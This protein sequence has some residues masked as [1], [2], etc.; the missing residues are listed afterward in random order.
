MNHP[1]AKPALG[2]RTPFDDHRLLQLL[3]RPYTNELKR[4]FGPLAEEIRA[5]LRVARRWGAKGP[6]P[7]GKQ[8][9]GLYSLSKQRKGVNP[10]LS[11]QV[12]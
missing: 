9:R 8:G 10:P 4:V 11:G 3:E 1:T 2:A 5:P 7:V 12:S 6:H